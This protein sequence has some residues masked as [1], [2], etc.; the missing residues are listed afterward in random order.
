MNKVFK[1]F[2]AVVLVV[3]FFGIVG[4]YFMLFKNNCNGTQE[5]YFYIRSTDTYEDVIENLKYQQIIRN[6]TTFDLVAKQMNLPNTFKSG[7]YSFKAGKGNMHLVR[8]IRRGNWEKVVVK[9]KSEMTRADILNYLDD[10]L[11]ADSSELIKALKNYWEAETRFTEENIWTIF[12]PDHYHFNWAT[13]GEEVVNRFVKEYDK[14]WTNERKEELEDIGLTTT[15][16]VILG[17]IV[18]GEAIHGSE[19]PT[20]AG[21]YLNRLRRGIPLQAD[22]TILYVVG[23]EGRKRVLYKDLKKEHPYNTYLQRGL[24]PGPIFAPEK[25]AIDAV[26]N[27]EEHNYIFMCAKPDGSFYHNFAVTQQQHNRNAAAYRRSLNRQGIMR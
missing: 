13:N 9:L 7:R 1:V 26:L 16:A 25:R 19:M 14:F 10:H 12:L 5:G 8:K 18:D 23:R 3:F 24:P 21:L 27:A 6:E 4:G 11:E 20:I 22:P 2:G 17:S 15:E